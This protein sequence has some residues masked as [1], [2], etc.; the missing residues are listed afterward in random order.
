MATYRRP[1]KWLK[2]AERFGHGLHGLCF[3]RLRILLSGDRL[4]K[5]RRTAPGCGPPAPPHGAAVVP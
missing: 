3:G 5:C 4:A 2:R 1:Q